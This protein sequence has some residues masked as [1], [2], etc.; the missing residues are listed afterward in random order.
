MHPDMVGRKD[1]SEAAT[2]HLVLQ[3]VLLQQDGADF[4]ASDVSLS[5]TLFFH[6]AYHVYWSTRWAV[7]V[8]VARNGGTFPLSSDDVELHMKHESLNISKV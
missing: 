3:S 6:V 7:R 5:T 2:S 8:L 1:E 4:V